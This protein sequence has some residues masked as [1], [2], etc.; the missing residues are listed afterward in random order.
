M[1]RQVRVENAM[2]QPW[3][4]AL[5]EENVVTTTVEQAS[6]GLGRAAFGR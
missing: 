2:T 6:T 5:M 3:I 1:R 4:E